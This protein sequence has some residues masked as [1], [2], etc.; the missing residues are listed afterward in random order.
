MPTTADLSTLFAALWLIAQPDPV[1]DDTAAWMAC[2]DHGAVV[3]QTGK[4]LGLVGPWEPSWA[5][6]WEGHRTA[7]TLI[8]DHKLDLGRLRSQAHPKPVPMRMP[9]N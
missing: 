6:L 4:W 9:P 7:G 3:W 1:R 8:V 5:E 2:D